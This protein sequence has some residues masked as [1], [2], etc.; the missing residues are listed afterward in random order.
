VQGLK[1]GAFQ[2][3]WV[4]LDSTCTAPRQCFPLRP[5][6]DAPRS[7]M[8]ATASDCKGG[9]TNSTLFT[10][11]VTLRSSSAPSSEPSRRHSAVSSATS[12]MD[13]CERS[14]Q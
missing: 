2:A 7:I 5:P 14:N 6:E 8:S 10:R 12:A 11:V 9:S 4:K 1:P 13:G 3:L